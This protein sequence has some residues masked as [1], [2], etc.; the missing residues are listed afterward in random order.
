M[1][2]CVAVFMPMTTKAEANLGSSSA[3]VA[4]EIVAYD[5]SKFYSKLGQDFCN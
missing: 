3:F 5:R 1:K 4:D 2:D